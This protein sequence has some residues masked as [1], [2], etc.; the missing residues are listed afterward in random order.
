MVLSDMDHDAAY[1]MAFDILAEQYAKQGEPNRGPVQLNLYIWRDGQEAASVP[2]ADS[3][4]WESFAAWAVEKD[5]DLGR[6]A[7]LGHT[8]EFRVESVK[9][10]AA[11]LADVP[12]QYSDIAAVIR[13]AIE[14]N[15][16]A[17]GLVISEDDNGK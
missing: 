10:V 2:L 6:L 12:E 4:A 14:A 7:T 16:D 11:Q 13:D 3:S 15:P 1:G 8:D 17:S 9:A 5:G